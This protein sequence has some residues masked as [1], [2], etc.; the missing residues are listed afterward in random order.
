MFLS[1][2]NSIEEEKNLGVETMRE[3]PAWDRRQTCKIHKQMRAIF[4]QQSQELSNH[5]EKHY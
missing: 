1:Q 3:E 5:E 4:H 2:Q